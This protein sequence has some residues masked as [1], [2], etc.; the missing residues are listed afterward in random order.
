MHAR[1]SE[2]VF[3]SRAAYALLA[4]LFA[5]LA[6]RLY[7][8]ATAAMI[9]RDGTVYI[10]YAKQLAT[11]PLEE[12]RRQPHHPL[13]PAML[14]GAH[15]LLDELRRLPGAADEAVFAD[16]VL[17]WQAAGM[18]VTLVGG[19]AVVIASF[20][21]GSVLFNRTVGLLTSLLAAMTAEFCQ[22]SADVL[23]D[24]PHLAVYLFAAAAAVR[25]LR[26]GRAGWMFVAGLLSGTAFLLRPE[27]AEVAVVAAAGALVVVRDRPW[28]RRLAFVVAV[29]IGAGLVAAP[30]MVVTGKLVQK[31]SIG[32]L[33]DL[34]AAEEITHSHALPHVAAIIPGD[35]DLRRTAQALLIVAVK[36]VRSLRVSL[37]LPAI[38]WLV[39]R[40]RQAVS[41]EATENRVGTRFA[42]GLFL[43][44]GLILLALIVRFDYS[45]LFS[46]RHVMILAGLTLPFSAAGIVLMAELVPPA[47]RK[48]AASLLLI[49][50][51]APTV[52]WMFERRYADE[53]YLRRAGE[54]IRVQSPHSPRVM[55]T[56]H[57]AAFYAAGEQ[58]WSPLDANHGYILAEARAKRPDWIVFDERR[59]LRMSP[60]FFESLEAALIPGESLTLEHTE[61]QPRR[62]RIERALIYRYRAP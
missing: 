54:W 3:P 29:S 34:A 47:R 23:T 43:L 22:L 8:A 7:V 62:G 21:L 32:Q 1:S 33:L 49:G 25:G 39:L 36:Y 28:R 11:H 6:V 48:L 18:A 51:I 27:G 61:S 5:A 31:K 56:R 44:H 14:L 20:T 26:D 52:P 50:I 35:A 45:E 10:A 53:V 38:A 4:I 19:L 24:M 58:V 57:Q 41:A 9:S 37:L 12:I 2:G 16:P 42:L 60:G 55:T 15:R 17:S 46:M 30:Y 13:Y 59:M 40:R